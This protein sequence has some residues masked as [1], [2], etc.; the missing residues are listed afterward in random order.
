MSVLKQIKFGTGEATPIAQTQVAINNDSSSVLSV[1]GTNTGLDDE[2]N[3]LYTI[4]LAVDGKTI[5]KGATGLE[6]LLLCKLKQQK[7]QVKTQRKHVLHWLIVIM[8][9]VLL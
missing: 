4:A 2:Q 5:A 8:Q 3:P 6:H 7:K 1:V 9:N